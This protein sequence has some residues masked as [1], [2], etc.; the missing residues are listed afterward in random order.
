VVEPRVEAWRVHDTG[1]VAVPSRFRRL[2]GLVRHHQGQGDAWP[3]AVTL[4]V[5][6]GALEVTGPGGPVGT[7]PVERVTVAIAAEGPPLSFVLEV[8]GAAQLLAAPAAPATRALLAALG[9]GG[10]GS[11]DGA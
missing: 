11:K 6:E 3:D 2:G 4:T 9:L 10:G 7:W 5:R 1:L 8:A